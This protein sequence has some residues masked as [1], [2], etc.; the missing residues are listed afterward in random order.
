[1]TRDEEILTEMDRRFFGN[2]PVRRID[3]KTGA[4]SKAPVEQKEP[5]RISVQRKFMQIVAER[6]SGLKP[7]AVHRNPTCRIT[8]KPHRWNRWGVKNGT[9]RIRCRDC[10]NMWRVTNAEYGGA[11][12]VVRGRAAVKGAGK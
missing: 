11:E 4:A 7:L 2:G 8:K 1:M 6:K 10:G 3:V 9:P 5:I 12:K